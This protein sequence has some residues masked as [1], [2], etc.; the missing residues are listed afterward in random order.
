MLAIGSTIRAGD[1]KNYEE[2]IWI[3]KY[4]TVHLILL[5]TLQ[6]ENIFIDRIKAGVRL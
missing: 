3:S 5:M 6:K 4:Y 2:L 1:H